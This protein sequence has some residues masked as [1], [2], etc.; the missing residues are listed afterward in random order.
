MGP[1]VQVEPGRLRTVAAEVSDAASML[2][3]AKSAAQGRLAPSG[4]EGWS[5]QGAARAAQDS[6][7]AFL[8]AL[9][10]SVSGLA[11][12]LDSAAKGYTASDQ[13]AAGR[14]GMGRTRPM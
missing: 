7:T 3:T 2:S 8:S 1:T 11:G 9:S 4:L 5:V 14:L 13:A 12:D 6:W 10:R